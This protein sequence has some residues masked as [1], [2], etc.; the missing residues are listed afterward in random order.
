MGTGGGSSGQ[1]AGALSRRELLAT[2]LA[3]GATLTV[4]AAPARG[5]PAA[6]RR[7]LDFST[8]PAGPGW[9][10][11]TCLGVANLRRDGGEGL[12]EAGSDVFPCDPRPVAFAVDFRFADGRVEATIARAGAG[13]GVVL[14][15][16]APRAY[17][18][19]ICDTE[20]QA[21]LIVRRTASSVTELARS[22][23]G[24][25][26]T[27]LRLSLE[28][29]GTNP[30]ALQAR[31]ETAAG[32]S[33]Q[34]AA[35]DDSPALQRRGDPGVLATARTL[36]PSQGPAVLPALGNLHLLP[37]GVQEGQAFMQTAVGQEVLAQIRERSTV[38]LTDI[39]ARTGQRP[40]PSAASAVAATTG[41]PVS[42][43]AL[44]RVASDLPATV[45]IELSSDPDFRRSRLLPA[46]RTGP[47]L[48]AF[49]KAD[50]LRPGSR[51]HWRARLRRRGTETVGP[52][53]SFGVLPELGGGRRA[54]IAVAAC[55]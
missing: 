47:F 11:W 55:A 14:R 39:V 26:A 18:A 22:V 45:R 38:A 34:A 46:Q 35:R 17:Y 43:G 49:A 23:V 19:A 54:R 16:V 52:T 40:R 7:R 51:V 20:Q 5:Q 6:R 24:P 50:G 3:A 53:R 2:G 12:L 36:F 31:L 30:T 9:P 29:L 8:L 15:R 32:S 10:G 44:L 1:R 13:A 41:A 27:P 25:V 4:G 37:Y 33:F 48:A 21:L 28:A 42:G